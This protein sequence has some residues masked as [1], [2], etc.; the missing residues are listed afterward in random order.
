MI[1]EQLFTYQ[2]I[3][4]GFNPVIEA[5]QRQANK[6]GVVYESSFNT[7]EIE[8]KFTERYEMTHH[9][10]FTC[11]DSFNDFVKEVNNILK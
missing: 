10:T 11:L 5:M 9:I 4:S 3:D 8:S 7:G 1:R 2:W 6:M